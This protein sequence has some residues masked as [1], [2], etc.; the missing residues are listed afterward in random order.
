VQCASAVSYNIL[1]CSKD[2]KGIGH[3]L[4]AAGVP[5][6]SGGIRILEE[7]HKVWSA[8]T[9]TAQNSQTPSAFVIAS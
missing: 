1:Q 9:S 7:A 6:F 3:P 8:C 5:R 4:Q 2:S